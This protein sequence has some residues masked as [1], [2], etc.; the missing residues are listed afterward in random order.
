ML[1]HST[2]PSWENKPAGPVPRLW[3]T[4]QG[5]ACTRTYRCDRCQTVIHVDMD[6]IEGAKPEDRATIA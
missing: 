6:W 1:F 3:L 5:V 4:D 2:C